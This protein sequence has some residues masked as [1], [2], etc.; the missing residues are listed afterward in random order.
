MHLRHVGTPSFAQLAARE[1]S[2]I[3]ATIEVD[4]LA[5]LFAEFESRGVAFMQP[6]TEQPWGGTD[7]HVRDPDGNVLSFVQ[8]G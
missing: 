5:T 3:L 8:F 4:N 1:E 6:V 7:F 2:L